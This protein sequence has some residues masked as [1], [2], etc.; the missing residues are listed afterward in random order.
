MAIEGPLELC[1]AVRP[2]GARVVDVARIFAAPMV[3][4]AAAVGAAWWITGRLPHDMPGRDWALLLATPPLALALYGP[5]IAIA[6]PK[7]VRD[8]RDRTLSLVRRGRVRASAQPTGA[9]P[10]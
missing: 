7:D 8:L 3:L 10:P 5:A 9:A 1:I 4:G 6:A 2:G